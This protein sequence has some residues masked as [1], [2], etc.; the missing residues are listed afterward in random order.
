MRVRKNTSTRATVTPREMVAM[1]LELGAVGAKVVSPAS[2]VTGEWVRWKCQF[3]CGGWGRS[4][5]CPPHSPPP[6]R[7][8]KMLDEYGRA[9]LFETPR[10]EGKRIAAALER[11]LFLA[12]FY[13]AFGLG[14]GPCHL[15]DE[16][17]FDEGCRHA[18]EARPS[19]EA[20]GIDVYATVRGHGFP[21]EV[22]RTH[23]DPQHYYGVVLVD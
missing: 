1:A 3:G 20:C 17:A 12:G 14:S 8:R 22:V 18:D 7:T 9:V 15:C 10:G 2:V 6:E 13:K 21:I 16:C 4:L 23:D 11:K 5:V 19:M